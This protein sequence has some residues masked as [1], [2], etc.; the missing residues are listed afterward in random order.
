MLKVGERVG[1]LQ[2]VCSGESC[3]GNTLD[4]STDIEI[5]GFCPDVL[6]KTGNAFYLRHT[7]LP[8]LPVP[9]LLLSGSLTQILGQA[10]AFVL[11]ARATGAGFIAIELYIGKEITLDKPPAIVDSDKTGKLMVLLQAGLA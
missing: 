10:A 3:L 8:L 2:Q 4:A 5:A 6:E 11:F 9:H 7:A 1:C